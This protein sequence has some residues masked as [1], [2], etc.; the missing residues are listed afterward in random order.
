MPIYEFECPECG[1]TKEYIMFPA[2]EE[3]L[4]VFCDVCSGGGVSTAMNRR[5]SVCNFHLKGDGWAK[6]GYSKKKS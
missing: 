3:E 5:P 4:L 6:D 2:E 1:Y